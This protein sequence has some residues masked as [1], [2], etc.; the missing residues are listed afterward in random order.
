VVGRADFHRDCIRARLKC[1]HVPPK[2][3]CASSGIEDEAAGELLR[4]F[5]GCCLGAKVAGKTAP[6]DRSFTK[7]GE[8]NEVPYLSRSVGVA[9]AFAFRGFRVVDDVFPG[10]SK[11]GDCV[12]S[13]N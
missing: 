8:T 4:R 3:G 6:L 10:L 5:R 13:S 7:S 2:I 1:R 9:I 12:Q 11:C